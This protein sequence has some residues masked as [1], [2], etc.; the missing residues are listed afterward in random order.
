VFD[1]PVYNYTHDFPYIWD[2]I[3]LPVRF[4]ANHEHVERVLLET[5]RKHALIEERVGRDQMKELEER[6][7][8][9]IGNIDPTVFWRITK[10]WLEITVRFLA[11]DHGV[12][13]IKD[14][15]TR[16]VLAGIDPAE[17]VIASER[18]EQVTGPS[19]DGR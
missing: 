8:I 11:P 16:D 4:Q 6:F 19:L 2:E 15:M 3:N 18:Q 9:E 17:I 1:E 12:R 13:T 7:G 5:A 10:N 14:K